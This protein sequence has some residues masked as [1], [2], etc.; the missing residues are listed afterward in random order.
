MLNRP[1]F[2]G[3]I[4]RQENRLARTGP[5][6]LA[7]ELP[8]PLL[9]VL[10]RQIVPSSDLRNRRA[11]NA[12]LQH[13]RQLL[14]VRPTSPPFNADNHLVPHTLLPLDTTSLPTPIT[15]EHKI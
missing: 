13:N 11:L 10:A 14:V 6:P 7:P 4:E 1:I 5:E 9:D 8:A 15:T 12:N 2:T 3:R